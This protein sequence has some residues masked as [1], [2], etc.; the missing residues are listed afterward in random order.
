MSRVAAVIQA[1]AG[2]T[3]LPGKVLRDLGG[4][5]V[6]AWVIAAAQDSGMCPDVVVATST[7][8]SDDDVATLARSCGAK[9][10]RGPV[11]DV[12]TRFLMA[13]DTLD[14][15][16]VVRLTSDCPLLDPAIIAMCVHAFD[17]VH[18][19]Y[20]T[21]E[22]E[23]SLA[24]GYDVEVLSV[25][26]LRCVD[27]WAE[28]ADRIHVTSYLYT[29]ASDFHVATL[30]VEPKSADLRVTLDEPADAALLD[31]IVAELGDTARDYNKVVALLR[32]R[33]DLAA[34]NADVA[35]KPLAAG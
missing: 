26:L 23:H 29:H 20:L 25:P 16:V 10:V 18:V 24:H 15:S 2:S 5:P 33:P 7:D 34:L 6:L 1:R 35:I 21:T 14:A 13:L 4:K 19:D 32:A 12:L 8:P 31:A 3:R 9:V 28:G 30:G 22:H 11:D 17:P 27:T